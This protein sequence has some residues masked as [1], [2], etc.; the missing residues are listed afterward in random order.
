MMILRMK[1][2][3]CAFFKFTY[4][5]IINRTRIKQC[6][7]DALGFIKI[8]SIFTLK[9]GMASHSVQQSDD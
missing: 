7:F 4:D 6:P 2:V 8:A 9:K 3:T 1:R 5:K